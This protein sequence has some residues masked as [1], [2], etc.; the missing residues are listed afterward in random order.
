[1]RFRGPRSEPQAEIYL[2]HAQRPYLIMNVVLKSAGDPRAAHSGGSP[3]VEGGR[4]AEAGARASIALDGAARRHIRA[5]SPGHDR[6]ARIRRHGDFLAVLSVYG[7]L[8]QR[9][10]ERSREIGIRMALGADASTLVGWVAK[11]GPAAD[12]DRPGGR[13]GHAWAASGALEGLLFG[14]TP[15]E[16]LTG[17]PCSWACRRSASWPRWCR[18]GE[19]RG[20]IRWTSCGNNLRM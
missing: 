9:V 7:V 15:T 3:D 20:S 12:R 2:P 13:P 1:M 14:V 16:P 17:S 10:R 19:R 4:S 11:I 5:R 8:A 6:A 18:H